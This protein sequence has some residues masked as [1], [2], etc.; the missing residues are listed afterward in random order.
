M[1]AKDYSATAKS[2]PIPKCGD[3][4]YEEVAWGI[5]NYGEKFSKFT[6]NRPKVGDFDVKFEMHYCGICHSDVHLGLNHLNSAMY[7][8]VPGHELV[9]KVVEVGSKVTKVQVGDHVGVGCISDACLECS[10]CKLGD[11]P[12]CLGGKSVHTYNDRKRYTHIGGNPDTQ[13]FGGYSGSNVIHEHFVMKLPE[14]IPLDK[15]GPIMC[16]GITMYDPLRHWGATEGKKM[17]IGIIGV[18]GLGTMGIKLSKALGHRVVAISTS[19]NKKDM[20]LQKG[21]DAFVV[22]TDPA[23]MAAEANSCDLILNTVSADHEVAHYFSL[24]HRNGT[25]V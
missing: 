25:I 24:L 1:Q 4:E 19:A 8:I 2:M 23:S 21:A 14:S 18:G 12:Y 10:T 3:N 15:V 7:P 17:C 13:T 22:S 5:A 16:A 6:I 9:G 11:E 20:A